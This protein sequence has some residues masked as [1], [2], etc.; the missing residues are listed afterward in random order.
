MRLIKPDNMAENIPL[1]LQYATRNPLVEWSLIRKEPSISDYVNNATK[2]SFL[3]FIQTELYKL[4][5]YDLRKD[6]QAMV[7]RY[8]DGAIKLKPL[9]DKLQSSHKLTNLLGLIMDSQTL[10]LREAIAEYKKTGNLEVTA[11]QY[12]IETFE[13]LYVV[14]SASNNKEK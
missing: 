6:V 1:A 3:N 9:K 14:R 12:G 7:I 5:P 11:V 8:L 2:P 10:K 4:T 13:I